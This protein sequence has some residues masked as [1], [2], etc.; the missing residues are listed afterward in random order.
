MLVR[1]LNALAA[2]IDER[3][4]K[5]W[6]DKKVQPAN[7]ADDAEFL[8]R[9][10]LDLIGLLPA[11]EEVDAFVKD[12]AAD[13]RARLVRRLL[14]DRRS[15]A[16]HWLTFWNDLLRNDYAGT[17]Y[18]D[19]GRRQISAWLYRSLLENKPYDRFVR[20]LISPTPESEGFIK[21]I[22]WRG[23]VNASQVPEL[24]FSQNVAQVFFGI[25]LKCASCHD[26]FIDNWKLRDAYGLAAITADRPD[27]TTT[28]VRTYSDRFCNFRSNRSRAWIR[29]FTKSSRVLRSVATR[30]SS[31]STE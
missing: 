3:F 24:Q 19:G 5:H 18:I 31:P 25:N 8:R 23:N 20:E 7:L 14:D 11:P 4:A 29:V 6:Q 15:W 10:Y 16:E 21:G 26:S 17:G 28:Q 2:T 1:G 12:P 22:K 27:S 9:V 13:K 30:C